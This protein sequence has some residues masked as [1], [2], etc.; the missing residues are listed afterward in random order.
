MGVN[1]ASLPAIHK[2]LAECDR[3]TSSGLIGVAKTML[4]EYLAKE[5]EHPLVLRGLARIHMLEKRPEYAIDLLKRALVLI[6]KAKQPTSSTSGRLSLPLQGVQAHESGHVSA[7][8]LVIIEE[9]ANEIHR[10]RRYFDDFE[11]EATDSG[12]QDFVEEYLDHAAGHS[13]KP[14]SSQIDL[15]GS[16]Q[17]SIA[18]ENSS[19]DGACSEVFAPHQDLIIDFDSEISSDVDV[20]PFDDLDIDDEV[21]IDWVADTISQEVGEPAGYRYEWEDYEPIGIDFD[22]EI[23]ARDFVDIRSDS[24]LSRYARARQMALQLGIE[25]SWDESGIQLLTRI[26]FRYWWSA[27]QNSLR[28]ELTAG[29][30]PIELD[31]AEQSREIWYKNPQYS[32][33]FKASGELVYK[34]AYLPW[35]SALALIRSF[36]GYPDIS[37]VEI[38]LLELYEHWRSRIALMEKFRGFKF[39]LDYRLGRSRDSLTGPA[40][41]SFEPNPID[42]EFWESEDVSEAATCKAMRSEL[43]R[44]GVDL[45]TETINRIRYAKYYFDQENHDGR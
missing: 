43:Q 24:K 21:E 37:E 19:L 29:L 13:G 18:P 35:P 44:I 5:G 15:S 3:L 40:W 22:E 39:Y 2:L 17:S 28:R 45:E 9:T 23:S 14:A 4:E 32:Q 10:G 26:F 1:V 12:C 33:E 38:L 16:L 30:L 11:N 7:D 31:L 41:L 6:E 42:Y 34:Y 8:D 20:T 36:G 27:T 25:Y